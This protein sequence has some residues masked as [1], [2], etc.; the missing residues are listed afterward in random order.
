MGLKFYLVGQRFQRW[1]V[2]A[3]TGPNRWGEILWECCCD[4]GTIKDVLASGLLGGTSRSCGCL[5][6]EEVSARATKHGMVST[7]TYNSWSAMLERCKPD[8]PGYGDRGIKV[9]RRWQKFENFLADMGERPKGLSIERLDNEGDYIPENCVW[10]SSQ[11]QARNR[12]KPTRLKP[13]SKSGKIAGVTWHESNKR[14]T[15]AITVSGKGIHLG[16]FKSEADA[17]A[18]RRAGEIKYWS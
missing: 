15:A 11:K 3:R 18:A 13:A 6:K 1:L 12:R 17:I 4:C 14:W 8:Y 7:P 10:A 9:C 2:L 16:S 5:Q